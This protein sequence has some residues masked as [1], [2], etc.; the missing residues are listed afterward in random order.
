MIRFDNEEVM[1]K[2]IS[3]ME[4]RRFVFG[5][6]IQDLEVYKIPL[7]LLS[8]NKNNGRI[9]LGINEIEKMGTD[10]KDLTFE[11]F[12]NEIES[13]IWDYDEDKNIATKSSIEQFGQLEIALVSNDGVV[14]DGNRRFT[15]LRKLN[16]EFPE[17][18]N[19]RYIKACIVKTNDKLTAKDI[20]KYELNVQ[21]GKEKQAEYHLTDKVMSIYRE[22]QGGILTKDEIADEMGIAKSKVNDYIIT[23]EEIIEFLNHFNIKEKYYVID[24]NNFVNPLEVLAK[25]I[26]SNLVVNN[27]SES[28]IALKRSIFYNLLVGVKL[29]LPTQDL[30]DYLIR[31]IFRKNPEICSEY[32]ISFEKQFSQRIFDF[33]NRVDIEDS[34]EDFR[35]TYLSSDLSTEMRSHFVIF[36]DRANR[37]NTLQ[38]QLSLVQK[39]KENIKDIDIGLFRNVQTPDT[40]M[41]FKKVKD[42][43]FEILDAINNI[44]D[45]ENL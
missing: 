18:E 28:E 13:L 39:A 6:I 29:N 36:R 5:K 21:F 2:C 27:D 44:L 12:N 3:I 15:C 1:K 33:I 43:L 24:K 14:I 32:L 23:A 45:D 16:R 17:N 19:F 4:T 11:E 38:G 26:N 30:R 9:F 35:N 8:Y 40:S 7:H 37:E 25:Y 31:D 20:K 22:I 34:F 41:I 42:E 10:F